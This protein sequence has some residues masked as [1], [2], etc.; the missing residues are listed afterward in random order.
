MGAIVYAAA[1][2]HVLY[3]DYYGKNVGP[4]G[5]RMVEALIAEV[6]AMGAALRAAR[7]DALVVVADDHLNVFS[8]DAVPALCVRVGRSVDRMVQADAIEFDRALDGLPARYPLHEDLAARILEQGIEDGFDLA[9]SW[10][11]PLDH[12]F[13]SPVG[14]L[15]G[16]SAAPPLVPFWVNCFVAPRPTARRCFDAG[17]LIS[18]VIAGGPWRVAIIATGGLSHFPE[19]SLARVG[20]SDPAF[21]RRV[22][23]W[24]ESGDHEA[25]CA[26]GAKELHETGSHELLNWM[27]LIGAVSPARGRVRFFGE[28]G[29]ID[30]AAVEWDVREPA[31]APP[32]SG[33]AGVRA[34]LLDVVL[35]RLKKDA[36]FRARFQADAGAALAGADLTDAER[37]ALV[38]WDSRRLNEL[39]GSLHLLVS[40]PH[41]GKH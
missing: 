39:G 24:I 36:A 5:R 17:R 35:Y 9:A 3:P 1:M 14:T 38:A 26:L 23:G 6:Q 40:I 20:Q 18:R 7:P 15:Y 32:A 41:L 12:A 2:S 25:L 29:R 31:D 16:T 11:A 10:S 8:Y 34:S 30:L 13:L 33:A 28:M 21:D 4:H 37:A 27:V 19:L 22:V